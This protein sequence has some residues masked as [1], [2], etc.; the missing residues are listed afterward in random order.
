MYLEK[1]G[2]PL[3]AGLVNLGNTCYA[4]SVI[5]CLRRI[6]ELRSVLVNYQTRNPNDIED[7][8]TGDFANMIRGL[9]A[10]TEPYTPLQFILRLRSTFER[11]NE[12]SEEGG[13]KQQDSEEFFSAVMD[14]MSRSLIIV[15]EN[16]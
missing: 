10:S 3:P 11:F 7:Q 13:F 12:R 4:N 2:T 1:T 16:G 6:P 14:A 15:D 8:F 5:Q 9:E